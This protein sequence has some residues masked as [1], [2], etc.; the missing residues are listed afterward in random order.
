MQEISVKYSNAHAHVMYMYVH[1]HVNGVVRDS[2]MELEAKLQ[3]E[4]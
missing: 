4:L 1:S 3:M 2:H